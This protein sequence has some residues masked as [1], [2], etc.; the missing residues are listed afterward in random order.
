MSYNKTHETKSSSTKN[1][2]V[3]MSKQICKVQESFL[4]LKLELLQLLTT[5]LFST[6]EL[7]NCNYLTFVCFN[8]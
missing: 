7:L 1:L 8:R 6:S 2:I 4:K 3:V 5:K